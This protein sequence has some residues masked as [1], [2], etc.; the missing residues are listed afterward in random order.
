MEYFRTLGVLGFPWMSIAHS[1]TYYPALI[2][3]SE[4]TGVHGVVFWI[5]VLNVF[6]FLIVEHIRSGMNKGGSFINAKSALLVITPVFLIAVPIIHGSLSMKSGSYMGESIKVSLIQGHVDMAQKTDAEF[7]LANF[8][9]YET[10]SLKAAETKPDLIVWPETATATWLRSK[11]FYRRLFRD[12]VKS[13]GSPI[14][15]GSL[16]Y[17][18]YNDGRY[19]AFNSAFLM[20][21]P[22]E[23]IVRD[24]QW[25]AKM[26]LVPF[27]EW[28]PYEDWIPLI[29]KID[30]GQANFKPGKEHKIL[31]L[32]KKG[33]GSEGKSTS[34]GTIKPDTLKLNVAVCFESIFPDFIRTFC[35]KGS[36][37]LV[38]VSNVNWFGK[39]TS[40]YQ[41][42]R[43]GV[44]RAIEN[45]IGVAHCSNSGISIII[46]PYGRVT[47]ESGVFVKEILNGKVNYF[48]SGKKRTFYTR[49]GELLS[50]FSMLVSLICF[51]AGFFRKNSR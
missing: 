20:N 32:E 2:Q 36:Q 31:Y 11:I 47:A 4:Y 23:S 12:I 26:R 21:R 13:T 51:T 5:C 15:S 38:V 42:A 28:F 41:H 14:L 45:R 7:T 3:Y 22:D 39:T 16:D 10:L 44:F 25:Y 48:D 33:S 1:Q 17:I 40:L 6:A 27:G 30:F 50:R 9:N 37:F 19:D 24:V 35:N 18:T 46:D 43:I 49:N 29:E 8:K 34:D